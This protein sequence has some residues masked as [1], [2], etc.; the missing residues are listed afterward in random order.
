MTRALPAAQPAHADPGGYQAR[1]DGQ[2]VEVRNYEGELLRLVTPSAAAA[3]VRG[4]LAHDMKHGL[5][6]KVGIRWLPARFDRPSGRPDLDRMSQSEPDRY[7]GLWR[8][9]R[10]AHAGKGALGRCTVDSTVHFKASRV[11]A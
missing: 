2:Q 1:A 9:T 11:Q 10:D 3:L 5:R 8:G 7:A 4:G 6:L